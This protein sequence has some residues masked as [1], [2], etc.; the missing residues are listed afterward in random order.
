MSVLTKLP[1][2]VSISTFKKASQSVFDE[3]NNKGEAIILTQDGLPIA[4]LLPAANALSEAERLKLVVR[5]MDGSD[6]VLQNLWK[7]KNQAIHYSA[8]E[9]DQ[10]S[11]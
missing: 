10:S 11:F 6:K 3:L 1:R 5:E 4:V 9:I 2:L 7:N 8:E